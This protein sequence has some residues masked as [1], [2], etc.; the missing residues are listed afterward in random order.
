VARRRFPYRSPEFRKEGRRTACPFCAVQLD[1]I[2]G[3]PPEPCEISER[4]FEDGDGKVVAIVA[5]PHS[6]SREQVHLA[7]DCLKELTGEAQ[8]LAERC[9]KVGISQRR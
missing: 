9:A 4:I 6:L 2:T 5:C 7:S 3:K 8:V 1:P